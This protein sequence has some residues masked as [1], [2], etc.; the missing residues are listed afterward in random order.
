MPSPTAPAGFVVRS[1]SAA[2][3]PVESSVAAG[4][5][6]PA[7]G[8]D[9]DAAVV[10]APHRGHPLALD[11]PDARV[12]ERALGEHARHT[13]AGG[14][15]ARVHDPAAAV[16][17]FEP[18]ALVELHAELDEVADPRGRLLGQHRDGARPAEPAARAQRVLRVQ[19]GVVVLPDRRRDAALGEEAVRPQERALREDEDV[20][21][22]RRAQGGE[23]AGDSAAH[24]DEAEPVV[25]VCVHGCLHGS[26]RL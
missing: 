9:A 13:V 22:A 8:D 3:P 15:A 10:V 5:D 25:A 24:D 4:G 23:E 6:L 17:A 12:R 1:Q 14:G 19:R 18:E 11:D 2:A 21:L 16:A 7:V 26:F 20:G